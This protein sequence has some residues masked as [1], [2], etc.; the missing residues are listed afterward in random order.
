MA[1]SDREPQL[2]TL[3]GREQAG[4]RTRSSPE[5]ALERRH[6]SAHGLVALGGFIQ[7]PLQLPAVGVDAL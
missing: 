4:T 2:G 5:L 6:L 1:V 3:S 7:L